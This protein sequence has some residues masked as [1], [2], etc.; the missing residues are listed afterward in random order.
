M[1]CFVVGRFYVDVDVEGSEGLGRFDKV[2]AG[3]EWFT[4]Y[5]SWL[6]YFGGEWVWWDG[7]VCQERV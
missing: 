3:E 2:R 5:L 7:V 6:T 1:A 4:H